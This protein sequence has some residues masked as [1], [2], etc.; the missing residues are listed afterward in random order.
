[1]KKY[2]EEVS[3]LRV[4]LVF[5]LVVDHTLAPYA[6]YWDDTVPNQISSPIYYLMGKFAFSFM[7][8]LFVF[9]SGYIFAAQVQ[10]NGVPTLGAIVKKKWRRLLLPCWV[11]SLLYVACYYSDIAD[12]TMLDKIMCILSG[13]S[14]LWF[15][16][17]LFLCFVE[18][19]LLLRIKVLSHRYLTL[20]LLCLLALIYVPWWWFNFHQTLYYLLFF[21]VGFCC[22]YYLPSFVR[23]CTK[24][25]AVLCISAYAIFMVS[26]SL[27]SNFLGGGI[28]PRNAIKFV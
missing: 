24:Q 6:A 3:V 26:Y 23:Y 8:E 14:H 5:L 12:R 18:L 10:A 9:I 17:M 4:L 25:N 1:M 7:L 16:S 27:L 28:L 15:L 11:F 13:K 21:Y 2:L 19:T 20:F 22:K